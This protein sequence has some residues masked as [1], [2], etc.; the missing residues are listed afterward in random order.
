MIDTDG[1]GML[2]WEEVNDICH[3]SLEVFRTVGGNADDNEFIDVLA[4][5]FTDYIF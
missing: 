4:K 2:S 1:N 5:F 3:A